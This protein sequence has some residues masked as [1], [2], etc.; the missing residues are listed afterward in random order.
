MNVVRNNSTIIF[1]SICI[2]K[3]F[4]SF[5]VAYSNF[6]FIVVF[7]SDFKQQNTTIKRKLSL[8]VTKHK[9]MRCNKTFSIVKCI[10]LLFYFKTNVKRIT[11]FEQFYPEM[12]FY[13]SSVRFEK[14]FCECKLFE[15]KINQSLDIYNYTALRYWGI[16]LKSPLQRKKMIFFH[17]VM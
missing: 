11:W 13:A 17:T 3:L 15:T 16:H 6:C 7:I 12:V 9:V 8:W 4:K 1:S 2:A 14:L 10:L 5:A